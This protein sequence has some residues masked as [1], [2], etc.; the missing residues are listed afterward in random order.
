[1]TIRAKFASHCQHCNATIAEGDLINW[2]RG[3]RG[4]TCARCPLP[5]AKAAVPA[6]WRPCGY[7]GCNPNHCDECDGEGRRAGRRAPAAAPA[8]APALDAALAD[9]QALRRRIGEQDA[10]LVTL[11]RE[12][13][14][15][16]RECNA[17]REECAMR[18]TSGEY[19]TAE[20]RRLERVISEMEAD[21]RVG[22]LAQLPPEAVA[23]DRVAHEILR[24][25]QEPCDD[26]SVAAD[27]DC[28]I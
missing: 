13:D 8:A 2:V 19:L 12:R 25:T 9:A 26:P 3:V 5:V 27:D 4:V 22:P 7:P 17:L 6:G 16:R 11:T 24:P 18:K 10:A 15:A 21:R 28:P 23:A 1:M 20:V 14:E